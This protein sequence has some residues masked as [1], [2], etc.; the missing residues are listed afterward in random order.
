MAEFF[1]AWLGIG[2]FFII[3]FVVFLGAFLLLIRPITLWYFKIYSIVS[4]LK[5][6]NALLRD[7]I[8][9]VKKK[10]VQ[11]PSL[12]QKSEDYSKYMPK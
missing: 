10:Q 2:I 1:G 7:L 3:F 8:D 4:E 9:E 12:Q 6:N 5:E 11:S